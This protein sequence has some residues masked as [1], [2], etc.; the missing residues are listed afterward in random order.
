ME[1]KINKSFTFFS[2]IVFIKIYT[3]IHIP[4]ILIREMKNVYLI[5]NKIIF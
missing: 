2:I 1:Y 3:N 4:M 5:L